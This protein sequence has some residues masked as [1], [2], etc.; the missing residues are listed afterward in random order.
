MKEKEAM[1]EKI[2]PKGN[3]PLSEWLQSMQFRFDM[4]LLAKKWLKEMEDKVK[5]T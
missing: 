3:K 5:E 1:E 2:L 4:I